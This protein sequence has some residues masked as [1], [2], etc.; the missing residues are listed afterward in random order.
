MRRGLRGYAQTLAHVVKD[1]KV[2]ADLAKMSDLLGR[3]SLEIGDLLRCDS[4]A[5]E[6]VQL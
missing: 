2:L 5:S 1:E 4:Q 3:S 6:Y